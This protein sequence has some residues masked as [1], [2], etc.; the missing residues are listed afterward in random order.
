MAYYGDPLG[1]NWLPMLALYSSIGNKSNTH[2][3]KCNIGTQLQK[4]DGKDMMVI[5]GIN[6][7]IDQLIKRN[8]INLSDN[9]MKI[10][11]DSIV[12]EIG[13]VVA[14]SL[15][16][17][18]PPV[19]CTNDSL[20]FDDKI[21]EMLSVLI[22]NQYEGFVGKGGTPSGPD[23]DDDDTPRYYEESLY[24]KPMD[25]LIFLFNTQPDKLTIPTLAY[26]VEGALNTAHHRIVGNGKYKKRRLTI[27][28]IMYMAEKRIRVKDGIPEHEVNS[29]KAIFNKTG[30]GGSY[31]YNDVELLRVLH[32]YIIQI[33]DT[34]L[35]TSTST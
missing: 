28:N 26:R 25:E 6:T 33:G 13:N 16:A 18:S 27:D 10:L 19:V 4:L 32:T 7:K 11:K 31:I 23:D 9:D 2:E 3:Q 20:V 29:I 30:D 1:I 21:K 22:K 24:N 14:K 12:S 8:S 17:P 34:A 35:E 15:N 5:K